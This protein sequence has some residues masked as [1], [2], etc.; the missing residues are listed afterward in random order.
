MYTLTSN[1]LSLRNWAAPWEIWQ[2]RSISPNLDLTRFKI[3]QIRHS[4]QTSFHHSVNPSVNASRRQCIHQYDINP[5]IHQIHHSIIPSVFK[6]LFPKKKT[7]ECLPEA[8]VSGSALHGLSNEDLYRSSG[9]TMDLIVYHMFQ[10]EVQYSVRNGE[11][12]VLKNDFFLLGNILQKLK[13]LENIF[14]RR[15]ENQLKNWFIFLTLKYFA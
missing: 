11:K 8:S 4:I 6:T 7:L 15:R 13:C 12:I 5:S 14:L 1:N 3:H 10:S 2:S 9:S